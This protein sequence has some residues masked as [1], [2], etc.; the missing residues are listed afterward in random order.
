MSSVSLKIRAK[1]KLKLIRS[2]RC[3][4]QVGFVSEIAKISHL[5]ATPKSLLNNSFKG[6]VLVEL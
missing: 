4:F 6:C 3:N 2:W 1:N 5:R